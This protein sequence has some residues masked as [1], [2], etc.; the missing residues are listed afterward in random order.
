MPILRYVRACSHAPASMTP[1]RGLIGAP[2][3]VLTR[4]TTREPAIR[5]PAIRAPATTA[6]R[7]PSH[8]TASS[9]RR[10]YSRHS[11]RSH[12]SP[13][14]STSA[15]ARASTG[16]ASSRAATKPWTTRRSVEGSTTRSISSDTTSTPP[17][18]KATLEPL[19]A[20]AG[21][22]LCNRYA[23][24]V[25]PTGVINIHVAGFDT[26][27]NGGTAGHVYRSCPSGSC[28]ADTHCT[29]CAMG[30]S[31]MEPKFQFCTCIQVGK[32][33]P[34]HQVDASWRTYMRKQASYTYGR[35]R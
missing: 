2:S 7:A 5:E 35:R 16:R 10:S 34:G 20:A 22:L 1:A 11:P 30:T 23:A 17:S 14:I 15:R 3:S 28:R 32:S 19:A 25:R 31:D 33:L 24:K 6:R 9:R 8:V 21:R 4:P 12:R 18:T 13:A 27:H 26:I 29:S